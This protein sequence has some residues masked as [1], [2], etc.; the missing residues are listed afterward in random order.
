MDLTG[1]AHSGPDVEAG[2]RGWIGLVG[3]TSKC[4][5]ERARGQGVGGL[6][7]A[8][9]KS[10]AVGVGVRVLWSWGPRSTREDGKVGPTSEWHRRPLSI[11]SPYPFNNNPWA[12][13]WVKERSRG[14]SCLNSRPFRSFYSFGR[15]QVSGSR[16]K[17]LRLGTPLGRPIRSR[18]V[19]GCW[20]STDLGP[21]GVGSWVVDATVE[22]R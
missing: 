15:S 8:D 5:H 10:V 20:G 3:G 14:V 16:V 9:L 2:D 1:R 21:V 17:G 4:G 18:W 22:H 11:A 7:V 13:P 19:W 12:I 6:G